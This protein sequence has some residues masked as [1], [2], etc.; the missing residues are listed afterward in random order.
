MAR[1]YLAVQRGPIASKVV[2]VKVLRPELGDDQQFAAMFGDESRIAV[3]LNHPNVVH[4]YEASADPAEH[5]I[6]MEFLEGKTWAQLLRRVGRQEMAIDTQLWVLCQVLSGLH[7]AH[8]LSDFDGTP[9]NIVH[10]DVSPSNVFITHR[11]EVKLVDFG[12]AKVSGAIAETQQGTIKGKLGYASPEQCLGRRADARSD[13][14]SV[15]VMLW[16]ALAGRR[17]TFGE[18]ALAAM[19]TGLPAAAPD[20]S[21]VCPSVPD[22]LAEVTRRALALDPADRYPS[23][24]AFERDLRQCMSPISVQNGMI[25][26]RALVSEFFGE[27]LEEV[28]SAIDKQVGSAGPSSVERLSTPDA[29][30]VQRPERESAPLAAA[31]PERRGRRRAVL[32]AL[33]ASFAVLLLVFAL[34]SRKQAPV[35]SSG[36]AVAA[37][38]RVPAPTALSAP[39]EPSL[40]PPPAE[41]QPREA[42]EPVQ[43]RVRA[44]PIWATLRLD[45]IV[46]RNP[47][48]V[49]LPADHT[50]HVLLAEASGHV[51]QRRTIRFDHSQIVELLLEPRGRAGRSPGGATVPSSV[52][53]QAALVTVEPGADLHDRAPFPNRRPL[54]ERDPYTP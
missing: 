19:E 15:G 3:R 28:R 1:V 4:T 21:T 14:Y 5:Y 53:E 29:R 39:G 12:I 18:S 30:L 11:G 35:P 27:E 50:D 17:R 24:L 38:T 33:L 37:S 10:R 46:I 26:L 13:V 40:A 54:D 9:L 34:R 48:R 7:Y 22:K 45:G 25:R 49:S 8:E 20:I 43:L 47:L 42:A 44:E 6:V 31:T 32:G 36:V 41:A 2:V 23:A 52:S 16:E 51:S